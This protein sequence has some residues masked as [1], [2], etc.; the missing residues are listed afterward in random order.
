MAVKYNLMIGTLLAVAVFVASEPIAYRLPKEGQ[1]RLEKRQVA[2]AEGEYRDC[3]ANPPYLP[4]TAIETGERLKNLREQMTSNNLAAY[5]IPS[6]DAHQSEYIAERDERRKYMSGFSGSSG[7]AI[8]TADRAAL[9]T[10]GRYFLQADMELDC[11][12]ILQKDSEP[13]VPEPE[14]WL[15]SELLAGDYV[16]FDPTVMSISGYNRYNSSFEAVETGGPIL[17]SITANLVDIIWEADTENTRPAYPDKEL[18]VLDSEKFTGETW[19][20]KIWEFDGSNDLDS[21]RSQLNEANAGAL[22]VA[23]LDEIAWLFNLRGEDIPYNP[24]FVSYAIITMNS[25]HLYLYDKEGR[26]SSTIKPHLGIGSANCPNEDT[27]RADCVTVKDYDDFLDDLAGLSQD[28]IWISDSM[29]YAI[30]ER[31]PETKRYLMSSPVLLMKAIKSPTEIAGMNNAHLKDSVA[32]CR[33]GSWMTETIKDLKDPKVGDKDVI[34]ELIV[35]DMATAFRSQEEDYKGLSFRAISGFGPNGAIIHY[36]SSEETNT[37]ITTE[38]TFLFDSGSQY[39]D[40]TVDITRTFYFGDKPTDFM[41]EAYT[42]VLLGHIDLA[43]GTFRNGV[44]GRD[45]D[46]YAREPLW[47]GGLDYK[48]GTGHGIGHFLNVH[49]APVNIRP[50]SLPDDEPISLGVFLSD[51]P[52]Y[53]EDN[54]FGIRIEDI[55]YTVEAETNHKFSDY[56]Y[57]TWKMSSLV[58]LEPVLTNF[59]M[60]S[61]RQL[62]WYN[63]Y[64]E[65]IRNE[66]GPILNERGYDDAFKWMESKTKPVTY[67]YKVNSASSVQSM[68]ILALIC[69]FW[70][71]SFN[72]FIV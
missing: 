17:L 22:V 46:A 19:Q 34:S 7:L 38:S 18:I 32:L 33:L 67:T 15:I 59:S 9:W 44:Y 31:V 29:S 37:A 70:Y 65:R 69:A 51:E 66:V 55:M 30:Y 24:M 35:E 52:G 43:L 21:V 53:Y 25:I 14:D 16:G 12:W 72:V 61:P 40:G 47:R 42:R 27:V 4:P 50:R 28:T 13:G 23:K 6:E 45:I 1:R 3:E 56:T 36:S 62:D 48:H 10:D 20:Q 57:M 11:N 64:T 8:V 58:P 71:A 26:L 54:S 39:L 68:A 41:K 60:F 2:P 5:I 63:M 49:E